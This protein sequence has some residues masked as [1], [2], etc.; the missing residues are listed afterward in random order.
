MWDYG[1]RNYVFVHKSIRT[2]VHSQYFG[3]YIYIYISE[4]IAI[5]PE[6]MRSMQGPATTILSFRLCL[7][8]C[9]GRC[10]PVG[11]GPGR[12]LEPVLQ[13]LPTGE[14]IPQDVCWMRRVYVQTYWPQRM[15][16]AWVENIVNSNTYENNQQRRIL[17]YVGLPAGC[18]EIMIFALFVYRFASQGWFTDLCLKIGVSKI[19]RNGS[20]ISRLPTQRAKG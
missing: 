12:A 8:P 1:I 15:A 4:A 17:K 20:S 19:H 2:C 7:E 6:K 5:F 18:V 14:W 9:V 10:G 11:D 3:V 16:D 13:D